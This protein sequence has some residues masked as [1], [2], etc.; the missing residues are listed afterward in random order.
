MAL[1]KL[2][3]IISELSGKIGGQSIANF[4]TFGTLKNI[5]QRNKIGSLKQKKQRFV[6]STI[7]NEWSFITQTQRNNWAV[8]A[9]DYTRINSVGVEVVRSG[10]G[11][12]QFCNQNLTLIGIGR[13][14][15][16]PPFI[17]VTQ[18]KVNIIDI[19]N[20][21]FEI[22]A[23]NTSNEYLYALFGVAN[24]TFGTT[25]SKGRL[26]FI[27]HITAAQLN[28]GYNI[29]PNLESIFGTLS[30]PNKMA[31]TVDPINQTTGNRNQFT[32]IIEN[33]DTPMVL[34]ITVSDGDSITIP[35]GS[36][37]AFNGSVDYGDGTLLNFSAWNDV[38]LTHVYVNGG[39]Y[40]ITLTGTFPQFVVNNNDF[41]NYLIDIRQF[42]SNIFTAL[43]F[44]GC[45]LLTNVSCNDTPSLSNGAIITRLF[46]NC[47]NLST[48][49]NLNFWDMSTITSLS[50]CFSGTDFNQDISAWNVSN[51]ISFNQMF[52]SAE[53][54]NQDISA[55]DV[56]SCTNF[57][58]M[59]NGALAYSNNDTSLNNWDVSNAIL[60]PRMF[61]NTAFNSAID[62]WNVSSVTDATE[63]FEL[64]VFNQDISSW[65]FTSLQTAVQ[66]FNANNAFNQD[67]SGWNL[68][69]ITNMSGFNADLSTANY[70]AFLVAVNALVP[71]PQNVTLA[72]RSN[73]SSGSA[74]ETARNNLINNNGWTI[75]DFGPV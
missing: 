59:F 53:L 75:T 22:Q 7:A 1:L 32:E 73:Y 72:M 49:N 17:P 47:T 13:I 60:M 42:G 58:N 3:A 44:W 10:F 24:L 28:A 46:R 69:A 38:N 50:E 36:V 57:T 34:E 20:G 30:F 21:V 23:N 68:L 26:K 40:R 35:F 12:F 4:K 5:T 2:G 9:L 31:V 39:T 54:F 11:T 52:L 65:L 16:A 27:G 33:I 14:S 61:R 8:A 43:Q 71:I 37:G 29:V 63:M 25:A 41:K 56:S 19:S 66:M 51:V 18:P 70:D 74:A 15:Q 62:S 67:I 45:S 55:W 64:S 48:F 6:T